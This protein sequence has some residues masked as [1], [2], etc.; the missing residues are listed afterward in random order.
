MSRYTT[1]LEEEPLGYEGMRERQRTHRKYKKKRDEYEEE[2]D[3]E[4][5]GDVKF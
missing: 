3:D 5:D 2:S 1:S 4:K